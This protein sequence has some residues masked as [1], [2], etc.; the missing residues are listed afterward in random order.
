[1]PAIDTYSPR[2][3][4]MSMAASACVSTSSVRNTL[5]TPSSL[6]SGS[7]TPPTPGIGQLNNL[8][9]GY[10]ALGVLRLPDYQM[11]KRPNASFSFEPHPIVRI[12]R[13]HVRKNHLVPGLKARDDF[14]RVHRALTELHLDACRLISTLVHFENTDRA[15]ILAKGGPSHEDDVG[16]ALEF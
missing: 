7:I 15:L 3:I 11:T 8:A 10:W 6:I 16:E 4:V 2:P 12:P 13:G 14:N 5:L 1:G 9:I